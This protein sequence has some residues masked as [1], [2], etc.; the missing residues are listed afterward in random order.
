MKNKD[1]DESHLS[2]ASSTTDRIWHCQKCGS[3][4]RSIV[5]FENQYLSWYLD[6][7]C[8]DCA[9]DEYREVHGDDE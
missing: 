7:F 8:E 2:I 3:T 6:R 4:D 9:N 1:I 5:H